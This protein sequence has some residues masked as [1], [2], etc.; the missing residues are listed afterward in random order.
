MAPSGADL[1][2]NEQQQNSC[3]KIPKNYF[4]P[5][6]KSRFWLP[7]LYRTQTSAVSGEWSGDG[8]VSPG[9][10]TLMVSDR[11]IAQGDWG[12]IYGPGGCKP[13][14]RTL[15][16]MD[17]MIATSLPDMGNAWQWRWKY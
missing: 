8:G 9:G 10:G 7:V 15:G 16:G 5:T 1:L 3:V 12:P 11:A 2:N 13:W 17:L 6:L 4:F 14:R